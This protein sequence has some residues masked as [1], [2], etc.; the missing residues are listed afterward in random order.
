[1]L[2]AINTI[3]DKR[4]SHLLHLNIDGEACTFVLTLRWADALGKWLM[5]IDTDAGDSV[6]RDIPIVSSVTKLNNLLA[7]FA[8]KKAGKIGCI[9]KQTNDI[10]EPDQYSLEDEFEL[11]WGDSSGA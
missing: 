4:Q 1:M 2:V 10:G 11:V 5:T 3:P 9:M 8:Y 6:C 7:P